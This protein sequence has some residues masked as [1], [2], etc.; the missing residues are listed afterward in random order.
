[1]ELIDIA[2][3]TNEELRSRG[4]I[5]Q[6]LKRQYIDSFH[7]VL[8][9]IQIHI[10]GVTPPKGHAPIQYRIRFYDTSITIQT[11]ELPSNGMINTVLTH[12]IRYEDPDYMIKILDHILSA[13]LPKCS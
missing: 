1:M 9:P 12:N 8:G 11:E 10:K 7:T 3:T 5:S 13:Y 4:Y 6:I 2:E